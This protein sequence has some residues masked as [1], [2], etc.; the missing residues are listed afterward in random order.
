MLTTVLKV[1][2]HVLQS[3]ST[4]MEP[5]QQKIVFNKVTWAGNVKEQTNNQPNEKIDP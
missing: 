2:K 1:N 5:N 4:G 3:F